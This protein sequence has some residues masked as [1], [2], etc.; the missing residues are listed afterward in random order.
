MIVECEGKGVDVAVNEKH[1]ETLAYWLKIM[2]VAGI[3]VFI[4]R[5]F[6]FIPMSVEGNSMEKTLH[7]ND[8]IVYEKFS[9]I[10]RFDIIIFQT[11]DGLT[12]VKRV[13]GL[14]GDHIQYKDDE[15]YINGEK[16][17]EDFLGQAKIKRDSNQ[18]TTNF[19]TEELLGKK[20]I[21]EDHFFVLG[22]NRR[23]S[24]DSRSFGEVSSDQILGKVRLVYFPLSHFKIF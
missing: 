12:Y 20:E 15:L 4:L 6:I 22:D 1:I 7:P 8:H 14:P 23:I 10:R 13:I 2:V 21:S 5:G 19:D 9:S 3:F 17:E 16:T 24:K 18:Y 11:T